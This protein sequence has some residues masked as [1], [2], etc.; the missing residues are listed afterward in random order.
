M[1]N[2]VE[3]GIT[4]AYWQSLSATGKLYL[5]FPLEKLG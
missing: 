2:P 3:P 5:E 4:L 1:S